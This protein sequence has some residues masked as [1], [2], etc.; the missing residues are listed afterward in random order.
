MQ[1]KTICKCG[2][3]CDYERT[4]YERINNL[5]CNNSR[6][7]QIEKYGLEIVQDDERIWQER[8]YKVNHETGLLERINN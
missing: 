7:Q 4:R 5:P 1:K 8:G 6:A 3:G 2:Q